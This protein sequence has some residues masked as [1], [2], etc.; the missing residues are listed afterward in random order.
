MDLAYI[1]H[2]E[3]CALLLDG[4][5]ICRWI[6][7]K[8]DAGDEVVVAAKRCVGA[9]YVAT[10]DPDVPG[11]LAQE[12]RIGTN[13]LF[14]V[15]KDGRVSLV[16]FGPVQAFEKLDAATAAAPTEREEPSATIAAEAT[17][18]G[19]VGGEIEA[20][21]LEAG[22][23]EAGASEAGA[24]EAGVASDARVPEAPIEAVTE[25]EA[26]RGGADAS[27]DPSVLEAPGDGDVTGML[28]THAD[29]GDDGEVAGVLEA[30]DDEASA[31]DDADGE[32]TGMLEPRADDDDDDGEATTFLD[33]RSSPGAMDA[34]AGSSGDDAHARE[35]RSIRDLD[36]VISSL[37][38]DSVPDVSRPTHDADLV[39]VALD[40]SDD[41][42]L[43]LATG[44]FAR[45]SVRSMDDADLEL[46]TLPP[47]TPSPAR[48]SSVPVSMASLE[49]V[50]QSLKR[51]ADL[52]GDRVEPVLGPDDSQLNIATG[53]FARSDVI[54]A[55]LDSELDV[56]LDTGSFA[57]ASSRDVDLGIIGEALD[58]PRAPLPPARESD[59]HMAET[60]RAPRR[61]SGFLVRRAAEP[62][63]AR[64][65]RAPFPSVSDDE[66]RRFSRVA[67][68]GRFVE[69]SEAP[70]ADR[71][72]RRGV[73][74]PR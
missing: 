30:H 15:V 20:G 71:R 57:H 50:E 11:L 7:P 35:P 65:A 72:G 24:T 42:D 48:H 5:G 18:R 39:P 8:A 31:P 56:E 62:V 51:S 10:L 73:L 25:P 16:R 66:T 13:L 3:R 67:G 33:R 37:A 58:P 59:P 45:A 29:D 19:S 27:S 9:Q 53:S 60:E 74:P 34:G 14:A 12:P 6:V 23:T 1:A 55:L 43:D 70:P 41:L 36:D 28:E 47:G 38:R 2:S 64:E 21:A 44:S 26:Q 54:A 49:A 22:A 63:A 69:E 32:V 68:D 46:P 4:E 61:P 40:G 17:P 52:A